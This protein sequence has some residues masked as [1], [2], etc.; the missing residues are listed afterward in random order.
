MITR[1][2]AT[3]LVGAV[4]LFAVG[5]VLALEELYVAAVAAA[6][7]VV[8]GAVVLVL[9]GGSA[10][11]R[12]SVSPRRLTHGGDGG[13]TVELRNDGWLPAMPLLVSDTLPPALAAGAGAPRFVVPTLRT[14]RTARLRYPVHGSARGRYRVGPLQVRMR[15]PFGATERVRRYSSTE[16]V[17]VHPRIEPLAQTLARGTHHGT[18]ASDARRLLNAGDE[19]YTM[20]EYVTGDDLRRVHWPSTAHRSKLMVRQDE[21]PWHAEATVFC[22]T[23]AGAHGGGGPDSPLERAVSVAASLLCHLAD[24]GYRVRLMTDDD[25]QPGGVDATI[26]HLDRLAVVEPSGKDTL[27]PALGALR[28][29]PADGLLAAVVAP[30]PG[31]LPP[32]RHPDVRALLEAGRSF[33]GRVAVVVG[34]EAASGRSTELAVRLA[35]AGWRATS[36]GPDDT[37]AERWRGLV[38]GRRPP[39]PTGAGR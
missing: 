21:M 20:R 16:E 35:A 4:L 15:D 10:A 27:A 33:S 36:L 17:V 13:V 37:L 9:G 28:R 12:R 25:A 6:S 14:G 19:F 7:L 34:S 32:G 31:D 29:S 1:R 3:L 39:L 11:M 2:G 30:P 24:H 26:T 23:R 22:D 18:G 5:R 8:V 38:A